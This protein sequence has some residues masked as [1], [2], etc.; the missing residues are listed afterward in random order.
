MTATIETT[1][2]ATA[3][4]QSALW[5]RLATQ[6]RIDSIRSTTAAGSGHPTSA[7]SAADIMSVLLVSYLHYD[8]DN[9]QH[10]NN[11]SL[12]L[13]KG[14]AAPL[15][16][17]AFKA[18]G[19]I[20]DEEMM[21][22]RQLGSRIEGHPTPILPWVQAATGSLGQGLSI[23]V[24][25]ALCGKYLD[26]LPYHVW[27]ILGDSEMAEGSVWEGF[28]TASFQGLSNVTAI[29]DVNRLGQRGE[30]QLGWNTGAYAARARAFGWHAIEINGHDLA[31]I[32]R[33][34]AEAVASDKPTAI[35]A[36]TE[37]GHGVSFIANIVGWHG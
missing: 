10:P 3:S 20:T 7:L 1:N 34:F 13:S 29:I 21:T 19:A 11:D 16:Y 4:D 5:R 14:H 15:L 25:D 22:L 33:A 18:A 31:E 24:G 35:V 26:K 2:T 12:I 27:V 6:L 32:D 23:G 9:P 17:A 28:E 30:T 8:Y 37:K 36:R